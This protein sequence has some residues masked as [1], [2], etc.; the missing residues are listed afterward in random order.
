MLYAHLNLVCDAYIH[1]DRNLS[2]PFKTFDFRISNMM[3]IEGYKVSRRV[4]NRSE[5]TWESERTCESEIPAITT[6]IWLA[7]L[8]AGSNRSIMA[9]LLVD[10]VLHLSSGTITRT[11]HHILKEVMESLGR[12][13]LS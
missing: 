11:L 8:Q 7:S 10:Y 5:H 3:S 1:S 6:S 2:K 9:S 13:K 4:F 12:R